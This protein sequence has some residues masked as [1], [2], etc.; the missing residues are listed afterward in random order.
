MRVA[1]LSNSYGEDRSGALIAKEL[2]RLCPVIEIVSFPFISFGEE[3]KKRG[4]NVI[5]GSAPPPSGGFFFK[6]LSGLIMD[7]IES[8]NLPFNYI[9]VLH[10]NRSTGEHMIVVGDVSLLIMGWISFLTKSY[11]LAPCKSNWMAPHL[12]IEEQIM[13]KCTKTVFT[14]DEL[15]ASNLRKK[16]IDAQFLGNP[17]MDELTPE[18]RYN[19]PEGK[20]LIG[21]LPGSRDE[22]YGNMERIV[23]VIHAIKRRRKDI[24]FAVSVADTVYYN[25]MEM[26]LKELDGDV[27]IIKGAFVDILKNSKLVISLAGTATEQVVGFGIP[28]VSFVGTGA[29]TTKRRLLGQKKLLGKAFRF[30]RYNPEEIACEIEKI[31][32]DKNFREVMG[33]EGRKRMGVP[34]GAKSIAEYI[35]KNEGIL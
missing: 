5:G 22:S 23:K 25:R 14:H 4:I 8:I 30:M 33:M 2:K 7:L 6:S 17:M 12:W 34:G 24:H 28:V 10:K 15:T 3:Y 1:I 31:L 9:K 35:L 26:E 13:K 21:V 27:D 19:P 29:Q 18:N 16:D 32:K 11:F 20:I